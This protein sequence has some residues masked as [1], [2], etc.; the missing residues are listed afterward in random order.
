MEKGDL[1]LNG[2]LKSMGDGLLI[3]NLLGVHTA[4]PITGEFSFGADGLWIEN[5]KVS[6]A[7]RGAAISGNMLELFS[8]IDAVGED[9]RFLGKVG[10]PSLFIREMEI[11]GM[12]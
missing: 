7:I 10:A 5:G 2:L 1:D 11:S 3:T 8:K 4:N 9:L 6:H 12:G